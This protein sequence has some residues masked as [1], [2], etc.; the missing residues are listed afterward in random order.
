MYTIS[1]DGERALSHDLL[2]VKRPNVPCPERNVE[3]KTIPGRSGSLTRDY[4]TYNDITISVDF[5][6]MSRKPEE[7]EE[8][9]RKAKRWLHRRGLRKLKFSDDVEF[10]RL[11]K[12]INITSTERASKRLGRFTAEFTC[13][14][15]AYLENG[16]KFQHITGEIYNDLNE[17]YPVY[18]IKGEGVCYLNVNNNSVKVNV[19]QEIIIDTRLKVAYKPDGTKQSTQIAGDYEDLKLLE[20]ENDISITDGFELLVAPYF[21]S[22]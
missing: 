2:I 19:G 12:K 10:F 21:C 13:D 16:D 15:F 7:W 5:N 9:F 17:A 3:F 14:P 1:L 18:H 4:G 20:G 8:C 6:F 22:I 11:V